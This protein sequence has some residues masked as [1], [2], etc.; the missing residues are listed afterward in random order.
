MHGILG[1]KQSGRR[2]DSYC[3]AEDFAKFF[4]KN[5]ICTST[6]VTPPQDIADTA[7]HV[8]NE[9]KPVM[10]VDA[11]KL[12]SSSSSKTCQLFLHLLGW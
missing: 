6:S 3:S 9:W 12:I 2:D 7:S 10:P 4:A 11:E 1:E 8:I 5:F